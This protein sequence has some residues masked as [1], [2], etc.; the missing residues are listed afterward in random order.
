MAARLSL[1]PV[2]R[3]CRRTG[4]ASAEVVSREGEALGDRSGED[5]RNSIDHVAISLQMSRP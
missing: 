3:V 5:R 4:L 1:R 2:P